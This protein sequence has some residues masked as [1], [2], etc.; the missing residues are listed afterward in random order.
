M[1]IEGLETPTMMGTRPATAST[2]R[3]TICV[4]SASVIR[5]ASPITPRM[6]IEDDPQAR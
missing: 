3:S 6:A 4:D 2:V 1:P 5:L